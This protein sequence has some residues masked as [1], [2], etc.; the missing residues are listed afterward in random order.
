VCDISD[1][2]ECGATGALRLLA[3]AGSHPRDWPAVPIAVATS[4]RAVRNTLRSKPLGEHLM[5]VESRQLALD[6]VLR[7]CAPTV[8]TTTLAPHPTAPRGARDFVSRTLLD[9]H[10]GR[11][12]PA[13]SVVISE[14]VTNAMIHAGT[15]IDV[16]LAVGDNA[17]RLTVRD[18]CPTLPRLP[19]QPLGLRGRGMAIVETLSRSCGVLP[20]AQGGKAVWSVLDA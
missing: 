9:Q 10:L 5:V 19:G 3:A 20:T 18:R 14:L 8:A 4:D 13:A 12:I 6:A 11:R 7:T 1:A 15:D 16:S 2:Q 17:L